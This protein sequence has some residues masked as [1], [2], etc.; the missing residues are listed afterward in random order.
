MVIYFE[1]GAC[2]GVIGGG[3][4][5]VLRYQYESEY[6]CDD[7]SG[8]VEIEF[9]NCSYVDIGFGDTPGSCYVIFFVGSGIA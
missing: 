6:A 7:S 4:G 5:Y 8:L 2:I 9:E 1:G 3:L